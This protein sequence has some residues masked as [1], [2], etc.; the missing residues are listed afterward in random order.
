[1]SRAANSA[2]VVCESRVHLEKRLDVL[3]SLKESRY[4]SG[5]MALVGSEINSAK[6]DL[7]DLRL[8]R[9]QSKFSVAVIGSQLNSKF[10]RWKIGTIWNR[11]IKFS[12]EILCESIK[13][14][15]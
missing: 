3:R 15:E 13:F 1:M 4:T 7:A 10:L 2:R 12:Q 14:F 5:T 11:K 6:E 8:E 9:E